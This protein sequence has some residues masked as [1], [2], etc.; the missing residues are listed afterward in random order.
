MLVHVLS[1]LKMLHPFM[2]FIT[3]E[4]YLHLPG[5]EGTIMTAPWPEADEALTFTC[6]AGKA[7]AEPCH[8]SDKGRAQR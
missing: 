7:P 2:P 5:T 6:E 3:E 1:A 4:I 8:G